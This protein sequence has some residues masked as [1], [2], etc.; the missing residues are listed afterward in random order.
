[1]N[2]QAEQFFAL[3]NEDAALRERIAEAVENYPGSLEI[4]EQVVEDVLLPIARELGYEFT[5]SD[6]RKYETRRRM[7]HIQDTPVTDEELYH[8]EV[9]WLLE[10]GWEEDERVFKKYGEK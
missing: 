9:Y 7:S 2:E 4:R 6:L 1:M 8:P 10:H 5:L 3:Y